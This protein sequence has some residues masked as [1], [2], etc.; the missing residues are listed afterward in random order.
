MVHNPDKWGA[1]LQE[2]EDAK[3]ARV[4]ASARGQKLS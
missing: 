4:V 1:A 2:L 3:S